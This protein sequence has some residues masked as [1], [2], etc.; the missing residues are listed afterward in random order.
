MAVIGA[1][2]QL[3][4]RHGAP[5]RL[6]RLLRLRQLPC[7]QEAQ[8]SRRLAAQHPDQAKDVA[9]LDMGE[10]RTITDTWRLQ[11]SDAP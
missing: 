7:G 10:Y 2:L 3:G 8:G 1:L 6:L 5:L 11:R 4:K 9:L